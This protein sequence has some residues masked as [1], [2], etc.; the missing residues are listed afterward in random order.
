MT[1]SNEELR[2]REQIFSS[3]ALSAKYSGNFSLCKSFG[4]IGYDSSSLLATYDMSIVGNSNK[5]LRL[6]FETGEVNFSHQENHIRSRLVCF[7]R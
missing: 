3:S 7:N 6:A 4:K 1:E 2:I 5:D